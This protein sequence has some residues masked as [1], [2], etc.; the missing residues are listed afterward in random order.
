MDRVERNL[1]VVVTG[2]HG[3]VMNQSQGAVLLIS[4]NSMPK[5][6]SPYEVVI[7]IYFKRAA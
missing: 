4:C 1:R 3:D 2:V 7:F 6:S 5:H